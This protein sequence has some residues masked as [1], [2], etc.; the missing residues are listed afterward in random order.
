VGRK[1]EEKPDVFA[2]PLRK[3]FAY[4]MCI[5]GVYGKLLVFALGNTSPISV[6]I[7]SF[8]VRFEVKN[9]DSQ[10]SAPQS[11]WGF[12]DIFKKIGG[13]DFPNTRKRKYIYSNLRNIAK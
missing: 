5:V 4:A 13:G 1:Y 9:F 2:S 7:A 12:N 8:N 3:Y 11:N 10:A 6:K